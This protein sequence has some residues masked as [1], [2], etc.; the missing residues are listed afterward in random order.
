MKHNNDIIC[1]KFLED[2]TIHP[3][4]GRRLMFNKGQYLS[5][6]QLCQ[7]NGYSVDEHII[8]I[9]S[10]KIT[11]SKPIIPSKPITLDE[12]LILN[13][14]ISELAD[15]INNNKRLNNVVKKL[16]PVY[17]KKY[18]GDYGHYHGVHDLAIKLLKM[19][20]LSLLIELNNLTDV[21]T[22]LSIHIA[23]PAN[24]VTQIMI[25]DLFDIIP[26]DFSW[27]QMRKEFNGSEDYDFNTIEDKFD[28]YKSILLPALRTNR[29]E[30]IEELD[31][32]YSLNY[33]KD[34][35]DNVGLIAAIDALIYPAEQL[36]DDYHQKEQYEE[37]SDEERSEYEED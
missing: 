34:E 19:R 31:I 13:T 7:N 21:F 3:V 24:E 30:L 26:A 29:P 32:I 14:D 17:L 1:Q 27:K 9:P 4:T 36:V 33:L 5:L 22:G 28:Y 10:K 11:P 25:D 16:L 23:N 15:L 37:D 20:D 18:K 12:E 8:P 6:V 2:P 35:T